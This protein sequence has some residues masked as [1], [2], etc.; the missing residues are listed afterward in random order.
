MWSE[1][2]PRTSVKAMFGFQSASHQQP[3]M[4]CTSLSEA[5]HGLRE[6]NEVMEVR[7]CLAVLERSWA[8][9]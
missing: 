5:L 9:P 7:I 1:L 6:A 3:I 8:T 4:H 2:T